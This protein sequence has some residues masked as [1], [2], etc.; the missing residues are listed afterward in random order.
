MSD[1][2]AGRRVT[3]SSTRLVS[4]LPRSGILLV[5]VVGL[6]GPARAATASCGNHVQSE[7]ERQA[8]L[9]EPPTRHTPQPCHGPNCERRHD[10]PLPQT[11]TPP[12]PT[13][14]QSLPLGFT[15]RHDAPSRPLASP[16]D[17]LPDSRPLSPLERPPRA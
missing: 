13:D 17:L 15:F 4:L 1:V 12:S 3:Q 9:Q 11:I 7:R 8:R 6:F 16:A 14:R 10:A 2:S 5:L